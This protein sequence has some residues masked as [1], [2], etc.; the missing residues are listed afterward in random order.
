[1]D[2]LQA[3]FCA[4]QLDRKHVAAWTNLGVLYESMGQYK[5]ALKCYQN[6]VSSDKNNEVIKEIELT[7]IKVTPTRVRFAVKSRRGCC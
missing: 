2:A 6:A 4:C 5:E 1:M 3:Y 7:W